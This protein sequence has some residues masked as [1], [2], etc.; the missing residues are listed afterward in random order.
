MESLNR[1]EIVLGGI[2]LLIFLIWSF[3]RCS[4]ISKY[5]PQEPV[6][7]ETPQQVD[8]TAQN[9]PTTNTNNNSN[10]NTN[11]NSTQTTTQPVQQQPQPQPVQS[12]PR[13]VSVDASPT[14]YVNVEGLKLRNK[15]GLSGTQ[16]LS[17]LPLHTPLSF[18][19]EQTDFREKI[20]IGD[21][22]YNEPWVRVKSKSG[23]LEGWVYG[24][25]VRFYK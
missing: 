9:N 22:T 3:D 15:P 18:M 16:V 4:S 21:I 24:G 7:Q 20:T 12:E 23:L 5:Q 17:A 1:V 25:G 6:E 2:I 11:N 14:I 8:N 13:V 19:N 10:T